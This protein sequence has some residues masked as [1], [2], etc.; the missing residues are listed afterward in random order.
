VNRLSALLG[1]FGVVLTSLVGCGSDLVLPSETGPGALA[2]V[3]GNNQSAP[4]GEELPDPLVVKVLDRRGQPLSDQQ[5]AFILEPEAPGAQIS[6][7]T[8]ETGTDGMAQARWVL[9]ATSGTQAV[10]A[11]VVGAA[12]LEVRF[13]A[14]VGSGDAESIGA[15]SGDGQ[16]AAV[17]TAL[18]EPLVVLITDGFGNPV[19]DVQV[20]WDAH[21]GSVDPT[22]SSTAADGRASTSWVL[23]SSTGTQTATASS[24]GLDGSPVTFTS[25]AVP[26]SAEGLVR[27]SGNEQ[28]ARVGEELAEP[29]VV[30]LVDGEGNGVGGRAVTWVVGAG[31]GS[32]PSTTTTTGGDGEAQTRWTLGPTP[33]TNTLSAVVSG[34]GVVVFTA[35]ATDGGSSPSRLAFQ[36]QPSDTQRDKNIIPPV[37][38]VV[39]D[40]DGERVTEGQFE[41][42]LELTGDGDGQLKGDRSERTRFGVAVFNDLKVDEVGDYRLHAS[43]DG[44]PSVDSDQFEI[45]D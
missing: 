16:T 40:Q 24:D 41:I 1:G 5:V 26:G 30:R 2:L 39:L 12:G 8:V 19:A 9:G 32:V 13:E 7:D 25:T 3:T 21:D 4:A 11:R 33:G 43:T 20:E 22:S 18:A 27:I 29:L 31:G 14:S 34:V 10:I 28:S 35:T 17:G 15:L 42:M 37:E 36:L 44:L 45:F 6:P 38:I 23:G